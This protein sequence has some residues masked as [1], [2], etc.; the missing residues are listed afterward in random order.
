MEIGGGD[1]IPS[2]DETFDSQ[3]AVSTFG[4]TERRFDIY[5]WGRKCQM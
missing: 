5:G 1:G 4:Y 2:G 3:E